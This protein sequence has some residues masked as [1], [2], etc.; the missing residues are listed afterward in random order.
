MLTIN[1]DFGVSAD[2]DS[3]SFMAIGCQ[4]FILP[5]SV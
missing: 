1:D 2:L 5:V 3:L 4:L